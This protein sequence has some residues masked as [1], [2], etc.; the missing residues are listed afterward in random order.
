MVVVKIEMW[1][2]GDESK[3]YP[4]GKIEIAN[5]GTGDAQSGNYDVTAFHAGIFYGKRREPYKTG[6]VVGFLRRLSPYALLAKAL[7]AIGERG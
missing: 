2:H 5:D 1:P 4:L 7:K 6:R 3:A